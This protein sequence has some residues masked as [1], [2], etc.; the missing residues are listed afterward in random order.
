MELK[1]A[2]SVPIDEVISE[3]I[4]GEF[5][6]V[7][8]KADVDSV[9]DKIATNTTYQDG[10]RVS[11]EGTQVTFRLFPINYTGNVKNNRL[12]NYASARGDAVKNV[13]KRWTEAGYNKRNAKKP[14]NSDDFFKFLEEISFMKADYLLLR[15]EGESDD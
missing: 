12:Q 7:L 10:I 5:G 14:E 8:L 13:F 1:N 4:Y 15:V 6:F 11:G 2:S 9:F 3:L